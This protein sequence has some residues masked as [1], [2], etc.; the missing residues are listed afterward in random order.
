[1]AYKSIEPR[2]KKGESGNPNGRPKKLH[3]TL[4]KTTSFSLS[5]INDVIQYMVSLNEK[6]L[7]EVLLDDVS[8]IL[9]KTIASALK[10][11]IK[12]GELFSLETLLNRVYGKPNEKLDITSQGEKIENKIKIEILGRSRDKNSDN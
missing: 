8:S 7:D 12:K 2:W 11:S 5:Q 9:E 3:P 1:M 6:Q 4:L 10:K